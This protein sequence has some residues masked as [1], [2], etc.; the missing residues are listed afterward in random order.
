MSEELCPQGC[1]CPSD[2]HVLAWTNDDESLPIE[3]RVRQ[4]HGVWF[5]PVEEHTCSG[6]WD[7][8][9]GGERPTT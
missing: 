6:T 8:R 1:G 7:V 3:E 5:C 4:A 2:V 9:V